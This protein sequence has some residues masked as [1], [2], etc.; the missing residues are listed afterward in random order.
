MKKQRFQRKKHAPCPQWILDGVRNVR[1][2][3]TAPKTKPVTD[4]TSVTSKK[5]F[6]E[7]DRLTP[8]KPAFSSEVVHSGEKSTRV[9]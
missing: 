1:E 4:V 2:Q 8:E 5:E 7:V 9:Q 6:T 3:A